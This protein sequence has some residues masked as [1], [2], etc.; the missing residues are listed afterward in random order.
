MSV[1]R[2]INLNTLFGRNAVNAFNARMAGVNS[3]F[4]TGHITQLGNIA[5]SSYVTSLNNLLAQSRSLS[6]MLRDAERIRS[7]SLIVSRSRGNV[8]LDE[9]YDRIVKTEAQHERAT[10]ALRDRNPVS[11]MHRYNEAYG[12]DARRVFDSD[13]NDA[14]Q[15]IV[16]P[17]G[18]QRTQD[19]RQW[20]FKR[21][22][23]I[24]AARAQENFRR[25]MMD[26]FDRIIEDN[27]RRYGGNQA[28]ADEVYR[29][30]L[31]K[32]LPVFFNNS[33]ISTRRLHDL[34]VLA[35]QNKV[36]GKV[37]NHPLT[38][39][40]SLGARIEGLYQKTLKAQEEREGVER[41]Y[42]LSEEPSEAMKGAYFK[43][44]IGESEFAKLT[45][46]QAV[47]Y[48]TMENAERV[49]GIAGQTL[50]SASPEARK[51]IAQA[52]GLDANEA[53]VAMLLAGGEQTEREKNLELEAITKTNIQKDLS[54]KSFWSVDYWDALISQIPM[55]GD[56]L[57]FA[58][59]NKTKQRLAGTYDEDRNIF[60]A[61]SEIAEMAIPWYHSLKEA[62]AAAGDYFR[63]VFETDQGGASAGAGNGG[64]I[65]ITFNGD[66]NNS[67]REDVRAG[68]IDALSEN[69]LV[70]A[71][72]RKDS[73]RVA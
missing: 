52:F 56:A 26:D 57:M 40:L 39:I 36:V 62:G 34:T 73:G 42:F 68:V 37:L 30:L 43:A 67:S 32:N 44:G 53:R 70:N 69:G 60:D 23:A 10:A 50:M 21:G 54:D 47:K 64:D 19:R 63:G 12:A 24:F 15:S 2:G 51:Y 20:G 3:S 33:R 49:L 41:S 38:S 14:M 66:F 18:Y 45:A 31:L 58:Q 25:D 5:N 48:G 4:I 27:S 65:T 16:D 35:K 22:D 29:K 72:R 1:S 8:R 59:R 46:K 28:D 9:A 17:V 55:V 7:A 61:I 13:Y 71:L 6:N 11:Y